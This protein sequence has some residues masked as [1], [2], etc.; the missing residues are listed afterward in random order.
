M[1][2]KPV[3]FGFADCAIGKFDGGCA[4]HL[5]PV[6]L[7]KSAFEMASDANASACCDSLNVSDLAENPK[8]YHHAPRRGLTTPIITLSGYR[9][10]QLE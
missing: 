5:P 6:P 10:K 4:L 9:V 1:R 7:A 8:L 2:F 3:Y